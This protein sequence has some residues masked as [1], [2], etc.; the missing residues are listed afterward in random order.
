MANFLMILGI[1]EYLSF[2]RRGNLNENPSPTL[3][4]FFLKKITVKLI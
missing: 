3:F 4:I 1:G 2:D